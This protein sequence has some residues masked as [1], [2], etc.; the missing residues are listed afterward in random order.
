MPQYRPRSRAN[1]LMA[2]QQISYRSSQG[3]LCMLDFLQDLRGSY[4]F[5]NLKVIVQRVVT[6]FMYWDFTRFTATKHFVA[7]YVEFVKR[8]SCSSVNL[9]VFFQKLFYSS[10]NNVEN[11][12]KNWKISFK[13]KP[14]S[15]SVFRNY[16]SSSV[17]PCHDCNQVK[18]CC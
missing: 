16:F 11:V 15:V 4:V 12:F 7:N 17:T 14:F 13:K 10:V 5:C 2:A 9:C 8:L 18:A 1:S 3:Y 6:M